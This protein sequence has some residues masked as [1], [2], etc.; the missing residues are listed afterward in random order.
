MYGLQTL[1]ELE[2]TSPFVDNMIRERVSTSGVLRPLEPESEL[3]A[4]NVP[5]ENIGVINAVAVKRYL[6]GQALWDIKFA[7]T[8]KGI[9]KM[10]AKNLELAR[11]EGRKSMGVLHGALAG[12]NSGKHRRRSEDGGSASSSMT[13]LGSSTWSMSWALD[14]ENPPPSSIVSRRD[15]AEARRYVQRLR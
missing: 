14:G 7:G 6:E 10:R 8:I 15:T 4:C 2:F 13:F 11:K 9:A 3:T 5:L 1:G 12:E